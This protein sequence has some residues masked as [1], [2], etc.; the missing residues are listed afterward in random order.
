M[1][2]LPL[3][4]KIVGGGGRVRM[5]PPTGATRSSLGL[6]GTAPSAPEDRAEVHAEAC[7]AGG[8]AGARAAGPSGPGAPPERR[9]GERGGHCWALWVRGENQS[10]QVVDTR[11]STAVGPWATDAAGAEVPARML[12]A[13]ELTRRALLSPDCAERACACTQLGRTSCLCSAVM[14]ASRARLVLKHAEW[15]A[16]HGHARG[17]EVRFQ[18]ASRE[19][20][21]HG[22]AALAQRASARLGHL[23]SRRGRFAEALEAL[24]EAQRFG[25]LALEE[26]RD[27]ATPWLL[28]VAWLQA[29]RCGAAKWQEA[30]EWILSLGPLAADGLDAQRQRLQTDIRFWR[31]AE[32]SPRRCVDAGDVAH[33]LIC[34]GSHLFYAV[35]R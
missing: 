14:G 2:T 30:E 7:G 8:A 16:D 9:R 35:T 19:A 20:A 17:A 15:L 28:G 24:L 1:R 5:W 29:A 13:E 6:A 32:L 26:E 27:P 25:D 11:G 3:P 12:C 31:A 22:Q 33:A 10:R 34:F 23:L 21:E 18:E 4:S